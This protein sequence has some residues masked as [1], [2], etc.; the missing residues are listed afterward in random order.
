MKLVS[1]LT[2]AVIINIFASTVF[3]QEIRRMQGPPK[4][5]KEDRIIAYFDAFNS[6]DDKKMSEFFGENYTK[7][8]FAQRAIED[9]LGSFKMMRDDMGSL[10]IMRFMKTPDE[11]ISVSVR[12][13]NGGG[14]TFDFAFESAPPH[15][16]TSLKMKREADTGEMPTPPNA[17]NSKP[18]SDAEFAQATDAMIDSAAKADEFSGVVLVAK[19]DKTTYN[20][21][22][23]MANKE[24]NQSNNLET[25]FNLASIGKV[26]TQVAIGQ[27][28]KQNKISLD[29]KLGKFLP[30]YPNKDAREKVTVRH[31][32][33]MTSGIGD[34]SFGAAF[35]T[36]S[37]SKLRS[38]KDYIPLFSEQPLA[39]EPGTKSQYSNGG[40]ILLGAIIERVSGQSYYEYV[41][42]NIFDP[43]EMKDTKFYESDE[44]VGNLAE[45]YTDMGAERG[46][47]RSNLDT[48][49]AKGSSAGGVYS[50]APDL[51]KFSSA[52]QN[53]KIEIPEGTS[54]R[55]TPDGKFSSFGI[56]GGAPGMNTFFTI[57]N[58]YTTIILSNYDPMSAEKIG[59]RISGNLRRL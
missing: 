54:V 25:K 14:A 7:E 8:F 39:F 31:L 43:L 55:K 21:A 3:S 44:K 22:F 47:R 13:K 32:L 56:A 34:A 40:Y 49:P 51:L 58:G 17:E 4:G 29:D 37:K 16:I 30:D 48:R 12:A 46:K 1:L 20:K 6:G 27:L 15:K 42:K 33:T 11:I 24:Q 38:I 26:F 23:G 36:I 18:L 5:P 45:G 59:E 53:G 10:E 50:T 57:Q 52:L 9:R 41:Q 28:L 35:D 2:L 19:A